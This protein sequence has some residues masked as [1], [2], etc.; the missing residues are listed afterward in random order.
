MDVLIP[1]LFFLVFLL[2]MVTLIGHGIWVSLAWFGRQVSGASKTS[3]VQT[4][5]LSPPAP[6]QCSNCHSPE[7]AKA[8][9]CPVCGAQRPT[10]TD[11]LLARELE[12]TLRQ[13]DRLNQLGVLDEVNL[14][15][16][17]EKIESELE[18]ILF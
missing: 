17:R 4:L 10:V 5:P 12:G 1:L 14:R 15:A 13:L 2:V 9:F 3:P 11:E 16:L 18:R 7:F 8:K 6:E